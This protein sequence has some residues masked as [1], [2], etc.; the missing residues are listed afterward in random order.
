MSA[1]IHKFLLVGPWP[2]NLT[3]SGAVI[4]ND[5]YEAN[6]QF[7]RSQIDVLGIN[8]TAILEKRFF[9]LYTKWKQNN[10]HLQIV[11]VV[12]A[13][14]SKK[15]LL[16][17]QWKYSFS[18]IFT[19]YTDKNIEQYLNLSLEKSYQEKQFESYKALFEEQNQKL[20]KLRMS[21][22]EKIEKRTKFLVESRR[23]LFL[24]NI[25]IE[26]FRKALTTVYQ[27]QNLEE[28]E[29]NLNEELLRAFEIQWIKVCFSPADELFVKELESQL[30]YQYLRFRVHKQNNE[31]GSVFF[32]R[33]FQKPFAKEE[34]EFLARVTEAVS[35]ATER[36]EN[37]NKLEKIHNYWK[38][39]FNAIK[40]A[41]I[42][43]DPEY[44]I[45]QTNM[46]NFKAP[47]KCHQFLFGR[48]TPCD[49]CQ[50]GSKFEISQKNEN[51][52]VAGQIVGLDGRKYAIHYY[53]N[54]TQKI[55]LEKE[56]L[57]LAPKA[58]LG[59]LSSSIAHEINNPLGG[60]L[61]YTQLLIMDTQN[62]DP[63][64]A[65]LKSIEAAIKKCAE[66]VNNLLVNTRG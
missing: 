24:T 53:R 5:L 31:I 6:Y 10:P 11:A 51:F 4:V 9:D 49:G 25:R 40:D 61:S 60:L 43:V 39:L 45:I 3:E 66:I 23:K 22:D 15:V 32:M 38:T 58:E 56:L 34:S 55:Q 28:L 52:E 27:S 65:D 13:D 29:K 20:L 33:S 7:D 14:F 30:Q 37:R 44:N 62:T 57:E 63:M 35:L 16:D 41:I 36:F 64:Y 42:L 47:Q 26:S 18:K 17:L 2:K 12:P 1:I 21:L 8:L 54:I 48:P 19:S 50:M 59:I 46:D